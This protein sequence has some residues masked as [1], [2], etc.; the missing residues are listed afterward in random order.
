MAHSKNSKTRIT[1]AQRRTLALALRIQGK[2]FREIGTALNFSEQRAHAI[3]TSELARLN[4]ERSEKAE[5]VRRL[6]L[7]RLDA[8]LAGC[9]DSAR[10]GDPPAIDRVLAI[11]ARRARLLG[12]DAPSKTA[13]TDPSGQRA[14]HLIPAEEL[15]DD[16]LARIAA[17]GGQ[18]ADPTP[19]GAG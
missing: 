4:G 18:G 1:A 5:E 14:A 15:S 11:M 13:L 17:S 8:L 12:L 19:Q 6:E 7:E 16:E 9:W 2:T 10:G 3:I